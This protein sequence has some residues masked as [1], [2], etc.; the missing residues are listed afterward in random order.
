MGDDT[1]NQLNTTSVGQRLLTQPWPRVAGRP[2]ITQGRYG[3]AGNLEL[4]ACAVDDGLWV[5]WFNRDPVDSRDG[6]AIGRWS[7]AL[8]FGRGRRFAAASISQVHAGPDWLEVLA[9]ADTG[10]LRRLVWSQAEGF[11]DHGSLAQ[12]LVAAS[13]LVESPDG[14]FTF[15]AA[16]NDGIHR[17][18]GEPGEM[19]PAI[20]F[21]TDVGLVNGQG[22]ETLDR[23]VVDVD[24]AWHIDHLDILVVAAGQVHLLCDQTSQDAPALPGG[25]ASAR[26]AVSAEYAGVVVVFDSG[27]GAF[28][29]TRPGQ[30]AKAGRVNLGRCE[31]AS[32]GVA[33]SSGGHE[34]HVL[35]SS[36]GAMRHHQIPV[37]ASLTG[38]DLGEPVE[39]V[40]WVESSTMEAHRDV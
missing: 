18:S 40:V 13:G 21:S 6:A 30:S 28:I 33:T 25:A 39:A 5:G 1:G 14:A 3:A 29:E 12:G 22:L 20:H 34:W 11:V 19:Y 26:L 32:I 24:A 16:R 8:R 7:G 27:R 15:V 38:R 31:H 10:E 23:P 36:S 2:G 4:V 9:L 17:F 37:G 35:T